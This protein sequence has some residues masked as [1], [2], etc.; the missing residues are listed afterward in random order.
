M[1]ERS[2]KAKVGRVRF[3]HVPDGKMAT[4]QPII[5]A[6]VQQF[7]AR[8]ITDQSSV[9]E[10]LFRNT[11]PEAHRTVNH[12][13]EWIVPGTRIHTNTVESSFSLLKRGLIG[14]FHRVS[15]KHLHRYLSEFEYRFNAR[16][17]DDRFSMTV[18]EMMTTRP[19]E[20]KQLTA[21]E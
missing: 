8:I 15:V 5:E 21:G 14:S 13:R 1:R 4:L 6:N 19:M 10:N 18:R 9:Y 3:F 11:F 16:K 7:P 20:F 2:T 12:S 17:A